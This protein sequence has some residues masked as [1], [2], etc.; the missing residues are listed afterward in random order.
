MKRAIGGVLVIAILGVTACTSQ[1][2]AGAGAGAY[3]PV[4]PGKLTLAERTY[5][6][7]PKDDPSVTYQP[8]VVIV[9]GG[10]SSVVSQSNSGVSV[11]LKAG[12]PGLSD[13]KPGKVVF[14]TGRIVGRVIGT[15]KT[16]AG[17]EVFMTPVQLTDV[18]RDAKINIAKVPV[19]LAT[20][21]VI[22][23]SGPDPNTPGLADK[24]KA[25]PDGAVEVPGTRS[26]K[27]GTYE[28]AKPTAAGSASVAPAFFVPPAA[29]PPIPVP[30]VPPIPIPPIPKPEEL[31]PAAAERAREAIP[32]AKA[33]VQ[34]IA[35]GNYRVTPI[36][37]G[38]VGLRLLYDRQGFR[39]GATLQLKLAAPTVDVAIDISGGVLSYAALR[40]NGAAGL[41]M[42]FEAGAGPAFVNVHTDRPV[43]IPFDISI[44]LGGPLPFVLDWRQ[45]FILK[46]GFSARNSTL[47][48]TA[49]YSI[50]G[51]IGFAY[52][53]GTGF[54]VETPGKVT[55]VTNAA[56]NMQ[57]IS[58]GINSLVLSYQAKLIVGLGAFGFSTGLSA[59]FNTTWSMLK[60]TDISVPPLPCR[61]VNLIMQGSVGI[62]WSI[63]K[64]VA[65]VVNYFLGLF[66]SKATLP[67]SG[68]FYFPEQNIITPRSDF[69]PDKEYCRLKPPG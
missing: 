41:R 8:D 14:V 46:T 4:P 65:A 17:V 68:G 32:L 28:P 24:L 48:V 18:V 35:Q 33:T 6:L 49:D 53:K 12:A 60:S 1:G 30:P 56:E 7:A 51:G 39:I 2:G 27:P 16:S 15:K 38:G 62:G 37:S 31:I 36:L 26:S 57:G 19:D 40:L 50:A 66:G 44:P 22:Q 10:A 59:A 29:D 20:A 61:Q 43:E 34:D 69:T 23:G 11:V 21:S 13:V 52:R 45:K 67:S 55:A 54:K 63:P 58:V 64:V 42:S 25:I 9:G 3:Q 47:L 5:G